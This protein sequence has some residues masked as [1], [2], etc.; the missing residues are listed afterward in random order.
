[1]LFDRTVIHLAA[2]LGTGRRN[3]HF[4]ISVV[5]R[6]CSNLFC[7][8]GVFF[9]KWSWWFQVMNIISLKKDQIKYQS[10][11]IRQKVRKEV[12]PAGHL[13]LC[14]LC[15]CLTWD[16][17]LQQTAELCLSVLCCITWRTQDQQLRVLRCAVFSRVHPALVSA[18]LTWALHWGLLRNFRCEGKRARGRRQSQVWGQAGKGWEVS[19]GSLAVP[20]KGGEGWGAHKSKALSLCSS[21]LN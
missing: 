6:A 8:S 21:V 4:G 18:S 12:A 2:S 3:L 20:G 14:F 7:C 5:L 9:W 17:G 15:F 13:P 16:W 10:F 11:N 1:M 19:T